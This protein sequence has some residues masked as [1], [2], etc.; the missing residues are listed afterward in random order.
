MSRIHLIYVFG[1]VSTFSLLF[2]IL[3]I[4][5]F[6]PTNYQ[7]DSI[8]YFIAMG[9]VTVMCIITTIY[10]IMKHIQETR[11]PELF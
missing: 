9:L 3:G 10:N 11:H 2:T 8:M 5:I 1:F 7:I 6:K 4:F